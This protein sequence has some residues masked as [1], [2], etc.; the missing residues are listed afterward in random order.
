MIKTLTVVCYHSYQKQKSD[1]FYCQCFNLVHW[2]YPK[3]VLVCKDGHK[4]LADGSCS[5]QNSVTYDLK[6][7]VEITSNGLI[8][9]QV[10]AI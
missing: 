5:E 6:K 9:L 3:N 8:L 1:Y 4:M 2:N 10:Q 7:D